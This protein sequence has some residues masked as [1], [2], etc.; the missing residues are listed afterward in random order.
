[1][2]YQL[3]LL[4]HSSFRDTTDALVVATFWKREYMK[5][6]INNAT[7]EV[8]NMQ[9]GVTRM[10]AEESLQEAQDLMEDTILPQKHPELEEDL[11]PMSASFSMITKPCSSSSILR[12]ILPRPPPTPPK[13]EARTPPPSPKPKTPKEACTPSPSPKPKTPKEEACTP[14]PSPKPKIPKEEACIPTPLPK[15]PKNEALKESPEAEP[16]TAAKPGAADPPKEPPAE[17][18]P[19]PPLPEEP[20]EVVQPDVKSNEE[21]NDEKVNMVGWSCLALSVL[22]VFL[23]RL[24]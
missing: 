17:H 5:V 11:R 4:C 7:W 22:F 20:K 24:I 3:T 19:L 23:A 14:S 13:D 15:T 1:M 9:D 2:N 8:A 12:K 6:A 21:R 16:T 10:P 18:Q